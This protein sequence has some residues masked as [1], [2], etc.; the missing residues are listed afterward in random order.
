MKHK[1]LNSRTD[2]IK[3]LKDLQSRKTSINELIP[4]RTVFW[5][6]I[7][8]IYTHFLD[9]DSKQL[10]EKEFQDHINK[11]LDQENIILELQK[12][13]EPLNYED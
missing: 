2:K 6:C 13:C 3:F 4:K 12:G 9:K 11:H 5:N 1:Q 10:T 7:N 8:D